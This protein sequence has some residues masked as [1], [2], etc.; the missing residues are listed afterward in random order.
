MLFNAGR[1]LANSTMT[2]KIPEK[3]G[4]T[5]EEKYPKSKKKLINVLTNAGVNVVGK[6]LKEKIQQSQI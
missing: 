3:N 5:I 1:S 2:E 4:K 6:K